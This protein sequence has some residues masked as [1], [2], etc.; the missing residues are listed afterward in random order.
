MENTK[1]KSIN[2]F[3][4]LL[5]DELKG[6][7]K[8]KV[9]A[10]LLIGMPL[11]S[12]LMLLLQPDTEGIPLMSLVALLVSSLGGTLGSVIL[13]TGVVNEKT[14]H[15]YDLFVIRNEKIRPYMI[16]AKFFAVYISLLSAVVLSLIVA[17][18]VDSNREVIPLELILEN[19]TESLIIS[20]AA[21][22]IACSIGILIGLLI[23]SVPAAAIA[24]IYAGNQVSI[25][26]VMPGIMFTEIE[27]IPF[28]IAMGLI[29]S[30]SV[31]IA[32]IM[33]F[34]KKQL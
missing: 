3:G 27:T 23:N 8:S 31:L 17:L 21:M 13:A 28:S 10:V 14:N 2:P 30:I 19:L 4:M 26:A 1:S 33:I 9:M 29:I 5:I 34:N 18:I 7:Y 6:F 20:M 12:A 22:A 15:V 11:V 25:I 32:N 16:L 24:A